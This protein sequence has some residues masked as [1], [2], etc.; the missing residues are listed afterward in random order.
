MIED[1]FE[2]IGL[3]DSSF[4]GKKVVVEEIIAA[5]AHLRI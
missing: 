2:R 5:N 1:D 4:S 3:R